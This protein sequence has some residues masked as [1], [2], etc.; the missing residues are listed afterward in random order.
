MEDFKDKRG[1][2]KTEALFVETIQAQSRKTYTPLYS[3]RDYDHKGYQSAYQIYMSS[4]DERDAAM[5]LVGSMAHWRKLCSLKWFMVG[6]LECQFEGLL[7][8]REDMSA[9]D[10]SEAKRVILEQCKLDNVPAARALDAM[11]KQKKAKGSV[12]GK[13]SSSESDSNITE[14]L[15]KHGGSKDD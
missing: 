14:F 9:R 4:I 5:K 6:R 13:K 3:L 15:H 12:I 8:W 2:H 10:S 7:Q 1:A 11:A